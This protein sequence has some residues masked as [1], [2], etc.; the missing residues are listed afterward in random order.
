MRH[1]TPAPLVR[2]YVHMRR[3]HAQRLIE[4]ADALAKKKGRDVRLGEAL[5]LTVTAG[6]TWT[7]RDLLDLAPSDREAPYWLQLG[8]TDRIGR[9]ALLPLGLR[10]AQ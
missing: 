8:P 1:A 7:N 5:E 3:D 9:R 6:Q 4:V 2:F 10:G